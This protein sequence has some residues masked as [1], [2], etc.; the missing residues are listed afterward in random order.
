MRA[1]RTCALLRR[2]VPQCYSCVKGGFSILRVVKE[3]MF[4]TGVLYIN[5]SPQFRVRYGRRQML[6]QVPV[7]ARAFL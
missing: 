7:C 5:L 4:Q 3:E 2:P 1:G 6:L